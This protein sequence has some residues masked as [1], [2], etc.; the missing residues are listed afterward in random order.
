MTFPDELQ[1]TRRPFGPR[2]HDHTQ[3]PLAR[4]AS[5]MHS[6]QVWGIAYRIGSIQFERRENKTLP[7]MA[8]LAVD[9]DNAIGMK[10]TDIKSK[11]MQAMS[12]LVL[13]T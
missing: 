10:L 1:D 9:F 8:A 2:R 3:R 13:V 6:G 7:V 5:E 4:T 11:P 12:V